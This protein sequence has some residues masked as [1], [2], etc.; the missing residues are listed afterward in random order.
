METDV[1]AEKAAAKETARAKTEHAEKH[2]AASFA[3]HKALK[4]VQSALAEI[5]VADGHHG[6]G[7]IRGCLQV[8]ENLLLAQKAQK[9]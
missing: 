1:M 4:A 2:D 7:G 6:V 9:E 3:L 8:C 5:P